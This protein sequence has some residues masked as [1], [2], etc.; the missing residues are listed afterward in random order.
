MKEP[1]SHV[2]QF[3]RRNSPGVNSLVQKSINSSE[4]L[5]ALEP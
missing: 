2:A 4:G 5:V 3:R 1:K